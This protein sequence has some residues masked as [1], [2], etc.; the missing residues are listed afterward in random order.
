M[1]KRFDRF[2]KR[3]S[4]SVD[5]AMEQPHRRWH[6]LQHVARMRKYWCD[7]SAEIAKIG[8]DDLF[9]ECYAAAI[10]FHDSV[11]E[12][13][14]DDNEERSVEFFMGFAKGLLD[15][16]R[17]DFISRLILATRKDLS[18][19]DNPFERFFVKADWNGIMDWDSLDLKRMAFLDEWEDGI[20]WEH[21][22]FPVDKYVEGRLAFLDHAR[23]TRMITPAV[24]AYVRQRVA[25]RI[26][27][28]G[29]YAGSF[30]P[31]HRGHLDVFEK[32]SKMFDKVIVAVGVNPDKK[33]VMTASN[34][35]DVLPYE[36]VETYPGLLAD[37]L[38]SLM[39]SS[40]CDVTLIRGVRN[41]WDLQQEF[42]LIRFV[43]DHVEEEAGP[44]SFKVSLIPC[45]P[46][47][48]HISS[49]AI[50][51][52]PEEERFRYIPSPIK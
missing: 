31:F 22:K 12:P 39:R 5:N 28:V 29:V 36:Q 51:G 34:A 25:S 1:E 10:K 49:S 43:G 20:S 8:G 35:A 26:W 3:C 13:G 30:K 50:R 15:K 24:H 2:W 41:G 48:A 33:D 7:H 37:Y 42:N 6:T 40:R 17:T 11:Y 16:T 52:L 18:E 38:L 19:L 27:R 14:S 9:K 32:A 21:R 47:L 45:D 4:E 23:N 46:S 44:G